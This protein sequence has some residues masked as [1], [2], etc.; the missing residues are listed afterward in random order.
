MFSPLR[1]CQ[2]WLDEPWDDPFL[3]RRNCTHSSLPS[4]LTRISLT[5][6]PSAGRRIPRPH[7]T[8]LG[9]N[10]QFPCSLGLH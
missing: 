5:L 6:I 9:L 3:Q 10:S 8:S 2:A 7:K 4:T 1:P